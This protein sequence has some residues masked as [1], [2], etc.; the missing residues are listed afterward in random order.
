MFDTVQTSAAHLHHIREGTVADA[1]AS[2]REVAGHAG[3]S[4][5]T[6]SNMLKSSVRAPHSRNCSRSSGPRRS[7]ARTTC[8]LCAC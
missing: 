7:A 2:L 1:P 5:R 8:S 6:V 3:V 4:V